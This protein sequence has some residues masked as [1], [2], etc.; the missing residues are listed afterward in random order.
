[1]FII[2]IYAIIKYTPFRL[3]KKLAKQYSK[4]LIKEEFIK[5]LNKKP[6]HKITITELVRNCELNRN[7]FYYYYTDLLNVLTE[8]F[9]DELSK[10]TSGYYD[11]KTWN[12]T[13]LQAT[14]FA[15]ENKKAVFHVY[16][17]MQR[18]E[19]EKF[20]YAFTCISFTNSSYPLAIG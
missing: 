4:L 6:F 10:I 15:R 2:K 18:D 7:T 16:H 5:L 13:L 3:E 1:M 9:D 8:V 20:L 14:E 12:S 19:L 11:G 17:S